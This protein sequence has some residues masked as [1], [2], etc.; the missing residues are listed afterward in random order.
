[1]SMTSHNLI[2][3]YNSENLEMKAKYTPY[4]TCKPTRD[5]VGVV[6]GGVC[7]C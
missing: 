2:A 7:A 3:T 1:M 5:H 6:V 4:P